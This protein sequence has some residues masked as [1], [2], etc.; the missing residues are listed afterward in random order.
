MWYINYFVRVTW[1]TIFRAQTLRWLSANSERRFVALTFDTKKTSVSENVNY[2]SI[3][4]IPY[5]LVGSFSKIRSCLRKCKL[6]FEISLTDVFHGL[7]FELCPVR[8]GWQN[9]LSG[10][11]HPTNHLILSYI[12]QIKKFPIDI[13]DQENEWYLAWVGFRNVYA[14]NSIKFSW[15]K[16]SLFSVIV[17]YSRVELG[18]D[19]TFRCAIPALNL[20][21]KYLYFVVRISSDTIYWGFKKKNTSFCLILLRENI[22]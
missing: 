16:L 3:F 2:S 1:G 13:H 20:S 21:G 9:F 11:C 6:F 12:L 7:S 14:V 15:I 17:R 10:K 5:R 22:Y 18:I 19:W 4:S 8:L